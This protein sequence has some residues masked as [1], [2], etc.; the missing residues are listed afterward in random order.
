MAFFSIQVFRKDSHGPDFTEYK[1]VLVSILFPHGFN[2]NI[3]E[4]IFLFT[5]ILLYKKV[6]SAPQSELGSKTL[7]FKNKM[8]PAIVFF[9]FN[10]FSGS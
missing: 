9:Y 4:E 5:F 7:Y 6:T 2:I 10:I 1:D 8:H 3:K